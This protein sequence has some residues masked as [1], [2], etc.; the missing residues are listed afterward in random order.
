MGEAEGCKDVA[1]R[2]EADLEDVQRAGGVVGDIGEFLPYI[3]IGTVSW[4]ELLNNKELI[5]K[6]DNWIDLLYGKLQFDEQY[7]RLLGE[8]KHIAVMCGL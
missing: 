3:H 7:L 8:N 1:W 2:C 5:A 6:N 4:Q